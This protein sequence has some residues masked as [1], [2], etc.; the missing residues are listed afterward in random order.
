MDCELPAGHE[1]DHEATLTWP[2]SKPPPPGQIPPMS[3]GWAAFLR[4]KYGLV[5]HG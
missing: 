1:G 3:E 5:R 2:R 4:G